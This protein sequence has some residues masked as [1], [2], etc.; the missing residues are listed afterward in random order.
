MKRTRS[1]I[2][3][4]FMLVVLAWS[5]FGLNIG[6]LGHSMM[7]SAESQTHE[8]GAHECCDGM[9]VSGA[10]GATTEMDHHTTPMVQAAAVVLLIVLAVLFIAW[11]F[12]S[13]R[14][15]HDIK[16]LLYVR[17]RWREISHATSIYPI[18]FSKGILHAK[19]Y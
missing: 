6:M 10:S 7:M 16:G 5:C 9:T 19:V 18:V 2:I 1:T 8:I 11:S 13:Q 15:Y 3:S 17:Q 14:A 4:S 12:H